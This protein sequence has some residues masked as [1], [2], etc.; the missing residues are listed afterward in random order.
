MSSLKETWKFSRSNAMT[1]RSEEIGHE[2]ETP[3][4]RVRETRSFA[5]VQST[6]SQ[7]VVAPA[8]T[9]NQI[10]TVNPRSYNE[11]RA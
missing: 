4:I 1:S 6:P 2:E 11:A 5:P 7:T 10:F 9:S 8:A 3:R